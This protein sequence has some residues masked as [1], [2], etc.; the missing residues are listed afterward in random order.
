MLAIPHQ[1]RDC[2]HAAPHPRVRDRPRKSVFLRA[3]WRTT[4]ARLAHG[5]FHYDPNRAA[6]GLL[7]S[8]ALASLFCRMSSLLDQK[9][10]ERR[11]AQLRERLNA[12]PATSWLPW[13]QED[14]PR[15]LVAVAVRQEV[16]PDRG[17]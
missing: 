9:E 12:P 10:L 16:G 17:Y 7:A 15:E 4:G 1:Q 2:E 5:R 6:R 11:A 14:H 8:A 3:Y 13:K